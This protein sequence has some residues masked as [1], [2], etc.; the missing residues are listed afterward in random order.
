[1]N[2]QQLKLNEYLVCLEYS[3]MNIRRNFYNQLTKQLTPNQDFFII[4]SP[5]NLK[6]GI[7]ESL[8]IM[9]DFSMNIVKLLASSHKIDFFNFS[10]D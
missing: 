2:L 6:N 7:E 1:M 8:V 9:G 5:Y 3:S 4:G 10:L